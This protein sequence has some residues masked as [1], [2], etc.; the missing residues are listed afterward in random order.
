MS[1]LFQE[2]ALAQLEA[3]RGYMERAER[4][5]HLSGYACL[6]A[7]GIA[8][9][10][11]AVCFLLGLRFCDPGAD[12]PMLGLV[13]GCVMLLALGQNIV[14]SIASARGKGEPVWS[15]LAQSVVKAVLPGFVVGA[16]VTLVCLREDLLP[17]LPGLWMLAYGTS[18]VGLSLFAGT[19]VHVFGIA[20]LAAGAAALLFL[21]D[22]GLLMMALS[23][24]G[25]HVLMGGLVVLRTRHGNET[26]KAETGE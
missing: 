2:H 7:G 17:L 15:A 14:F 20:F 13:W 16:V 21:Q 23:F 19:H 4:Y 18:L 3:I 6:V 22:Q 1:S 11:S 26:S 9:A 5:T 12:R 8:I 24:G 25:L 10:G